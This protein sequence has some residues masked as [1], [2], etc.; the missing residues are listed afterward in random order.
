MQ[1]SYEEKLC[2]YSL[3][4]QGPSNSLG[5]MSPTSTDDQPQRVT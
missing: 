4:K 1:T 5:V 3:Y 2:L